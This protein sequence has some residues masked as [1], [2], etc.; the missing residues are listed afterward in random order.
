MIFSFFG[1]FYKLKLCYLQWRAN[2]GQYFG[3]AYY[4]LGK[5]SWGWS[6]KERWI[7]VRPWE[8]RVKVKSTNIKK[9][10][11]KK[12]DKSGKAT[13]S[14]A[15]KI[16]LTVKPP[17]LSNGKGLTQARKLPEPAGEKKQASQ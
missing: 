13:V 7:A 3:H 15:M 16:I 5:E 4:D 11:S 8:T 1:K 6:W 10:Q 14:P 12:V 2:S 17:P 9:I